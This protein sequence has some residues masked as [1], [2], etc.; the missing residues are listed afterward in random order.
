MTLFDHIKMGLMLLV[1]FG[2]PVLFLIYVHKIDKG[3]YK[4]VIGDLS[5]EVKEQL[6]HAE[7]Q[8]VTNWEKKILWHQMDSGRH[9]RGLSVLFFVMVVIMW[10]LAWTASSVNII[11]GCLIT[12]AMFEVA[13]FFVIYKNE[14]HLLPWCRNYRTKGY[15]THAFVH[16]SGASYTIAYYHCKKRKIVLQDISIDLSNSKDRLSLEGEVIDIVIHKRGK[17]EKV[18]AVPLEEYSADNRKLNKNAKEHLKNKIILYVI[19]I[20]PAV[21]GGYITLSLDLN[22]KAVSYLIAIVE[23]FLYYFVKWLQGKNR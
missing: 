4:R 11:I 10:F 1:I 9:F 15:V 19:L 3:Y 12:Y 21:I 23:V 7:R 8:K 2:I 5:D 16:S 14:R 22:I 13:T 20:I 18:V 17:Y 6:I